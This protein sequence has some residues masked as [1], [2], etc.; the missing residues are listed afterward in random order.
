VSRPL[1]AFL[2]DYGPGTEHVGALHAVVAARCPDADRLDLAHDVAPGDVR[3]GALLLSRLTRVVPAGVVCAIVDPGVG[4]ER[5]ALAVALEG[6]RVVVGPDNGLL[7]PVADDLGA[8][9]AVSLE[10]PAHRREPVAPTFHGRD[11]F[12]PAAAHLATG[13]AL[14]DLGPP[15]DPATIVRPR[16]TP[17]ATGPGR[18][19][20]LSVGRDRFGN[21]AL[22]AGPEDLAAA[23]LAAGQQLWV[24]VADRR[25]RALC[26]RVFAD[27]PRGGLLVYVDAHGM[28]ALAVSGG[29][30]AERL[31][32]APGE[33]VSL[34]AMD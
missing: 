5:R 23:G 11:V 12:A 18:L 13:G 14:A 2:T 32:I 10:S 29:S 4:T 20:A 1:V 3:W 16:L 25:H 22:L 19:D 30:A 17:P 27:A 28:V 21:L 33:A 24:V 9:G 34:Q 15:V 6:G 7:G 8:S 31:R 26:G